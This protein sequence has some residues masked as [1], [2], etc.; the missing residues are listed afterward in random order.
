MHFF[1]CF[2]QILYWMQWA[3]TQKWFVLWFIVIFWLIKSPNWIGYLY[4]TLK[5]QEWT[6]KF[7]NCYG[8]LVDDIKNQ[9]N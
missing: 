4:T 5:M 9:I 1:I 8:C 7:T 3:Y 2:V 6:A